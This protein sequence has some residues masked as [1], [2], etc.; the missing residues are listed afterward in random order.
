M[1]FFRHV[2]FWMRRRDLET[3]FDEEVRQHLEL[4]VQENIARGMSR[5]EALRLARSEFGNPTLAKERA[6]R[7]WGF[8]FVEST[9]HDLRYGVRQL[10][11]NPGFTA[12]AVLTLAVGIGATT[13]VFSVVN[14]V[15]LRPLP[16]HDPQR[17]V[18]IWEPDPHIP[19]VPLEAWGPLNA[20]FYDWQRLSHSFSELALFT[21]NDLNLSVNGTAIRTSGSRVTGDFFHLLGVAPKLGRAVKPE[22]D[23][24]GKE[25][26]AVISHAL[27]QSVF[28][29][30]R[31]VLGK[32]LLLD[33]K[34]YRIIGVMPAG[35]AFPHGN[36][37]ADTLGRTTDVW[38]PW[39]M[40]DKE[41]ASRDDGSGQAI[42]RLK[43]GVSLSEAQAE[44]SVIV[45]GLNYLRPPM[46]QGCQAVVRPFPISVTG[47]SRPVL[48]IFMGAVFLV[49]LIACANV[50]SL[51]LARAT[52]RRLEISV[53]S[54]L[55]ASRLRIV[56]Q[57]A[58]ESLCLA[59]AGAILGG[60]AAFACIHLLKSVTSINVP[61][62]DEVSIDA[63]VLLFTIIVSVASSLLF[64]L[65]P[66]LSSSRGNVNTMLQSSSNRSI[67]GA[68]GRLQRGLLIGEVML[69]IVLLTGSGLLI[70]SFLKLISLDKGFSSRATVAM[71]LRLDPR[72]STPER[73]I[74]FFRNLVDRASA[75]PGVESAGAIDFG[76]LSGGQSISLMEVEGHPYDER[77]SFESRSITP[78]YFATL[79]IPLLAGRSFTDDDIRG[80]PPVAIVSRSFAETYFPG[81]SAIG[82]QFHP[83][84][85]KVKSNWRTIVGVVADVRQF[86]LDQTPPMQI[87]GPLWQS[88]SDRV[89]VVIRSSIGADHVVTEMRGMVH[90]LDPALAI[91]D[92]HTMSEL[93]SDAAGERRFQTLLLSAFGG[94]ALVLSLV[95]LYALMAYS[96]QQR[97][98]EIGIRMALGA[99]RSS[100][101][102]LILKEGSTLAFAG[103]VLGVACAWAATRL[104]ASLLFE[105]RPTD[106]L[107]FLGVAG[108]FCAVA[109]LACY[110]PARRAT[111]VDPMV[112]LR[113]E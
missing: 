1:K 22:D 59:G 30:D 35:F 78:H 96:V 66:A 8:P 84:E 37:S 57:L 25:Q 56:R 58:T 14:A 42:A 87:Y 3:D 83:P 101:M 47:A 45:A 26:V 93:I 62:L 4:K 2:W 94:I 32:E 23:Q 108:L 75:L 60:A 88:S 10:W 31:D 48:L 97:T 49:L 92:V 77:T 73:Q 18:F 5:A 53:R 43:A 107:T 52:G 103:V 111:R 9:M 81:Q 46:F 28:A 24:P 80:R 29:A 90:E 82:K 50:A 86:S 100:V 76:P 27:W 39:A 51:V 110:V 102:R 11:K 98:A 55:G 38:I 106:S 104:L 44:M 99:Q 19:N 113:H 63:Q 71:S 21:T 74:A 112:A 109:V 40:T 79:G 13:T 41:K 36:E 34:P 89:S 65:L 85:E 72:Y 95:G 7:S 64:G 20:E 54:A 16:Y 61:R 12:I 68:V 6:R 69:T 15:L 91:A 17:L 33:A 70:R 67:K 105:V